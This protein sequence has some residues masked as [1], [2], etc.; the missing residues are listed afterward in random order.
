MSRDLI[1]SKGA[2]A[3]QRLFE[4]ARRDTGQCRHIARFLLGLYNGSRFP[5]DMTDLRAIDADL[6]E[7]CMLVLRMDAQVT[8]Q[9]VHQY[10]GGKG[11][12]EQLAVRWGV[13]DAEKLRADAER[14]AQPAGTPAPL[15]DGGMHQA[16]LHTY[17]DAPGYRDVSIYVK[18]GEQQN[19]EVELRLTPADSEAVMRHVAR[20]HA[21]AWK[22]GSRGPLDM[23]EGERRPRWLDI[24]PGDWS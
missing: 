2:A 22:N 21:L 18:L 23:R 13:E 24:A 7:D 4:V 19:T 10:V 8:E 11:G 6:F 9:E 1:E 3:L 14:A 17:G 12:F 15:H 16:T 20:V 5:F